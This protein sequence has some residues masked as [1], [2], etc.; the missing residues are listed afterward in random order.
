MKSE[1]ISEALISKYINKS[2][3]QKKNFYKTSHEK[4]SKL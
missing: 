4:L 3:K 1:S 2:K